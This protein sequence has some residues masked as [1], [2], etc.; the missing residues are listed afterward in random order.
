MRT[1]VIE[2]GGM[3]SP[4]SDLAV[5]K[6]RSADARLVLSAIGAYQLLEALKAAERLS[7][8]E[9]AHRLGYILG[10]GRFRLPR[11]NRE[12]AHVA[13]TA[14]HQRLFGNAQ[15]Q[16]CL[17]HTRPEPV[18]GLINPLRMSRA[19]AALGYLGHGGTYDT[20]R[21]LFVNRCSWAHALMQSAALLRL[22]P[23]T[24]L[25]GAELAVIRG[26]GDPAIVLRHQWA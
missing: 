25:S 11:T 2:V 19:S 24:V 16:P 12:L 10:P 4:L 23:Q 17:T 1:T 22:D 6:R 8:R 15:A 7:E 9:I 13:E 18:L 14:T 5:Q 26:D 21:L 3:L 20:A